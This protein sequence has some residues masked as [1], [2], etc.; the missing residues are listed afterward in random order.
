[1]V[2]MIFAQNVDKREL[3]F[4]EEA[5]IWRNES[6]KLVLFFL[7]QKVHTISLTITAPNHDLVKKV[8]E[9]MPNI[10]DANKKKRFN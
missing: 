8:F 2:L 3:N 1:M 10:V 4:K 7:L 9:D 6:I 5:G